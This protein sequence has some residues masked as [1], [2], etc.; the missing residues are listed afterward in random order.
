MKGKIVLK[1]DHYIV[2]W[3]NGFA[4]IFDKSFDQLCNTREKYVLEELSRNGVENALI[5]SPAQLD[6]LRGYH[7]PSLEEYLNV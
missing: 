4:G 3:G 2:R 6:E 7:K 5:I 1:S